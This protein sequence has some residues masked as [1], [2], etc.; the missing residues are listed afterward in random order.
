M[1]TTPSTSAR[2]GPQC[3]RAEH[4]VDAIADELTE[5]HEVA[6][7]TDTSANVMVLPTET[8]SPWEPLSLSD[9]YPAFALLYAELA[10]DEGNTDAEAALLRSRVHAHLSAGLA[11][12]AP[13]RHPSL[14]G[15][16]VSLAF[17]AHAA[18]VSFGGYAT[19]LSRLD[20]AIAAQIRQR[21]E[22]DRDRIAAGQPIGRWDGYDVISGTSG[23]G[24]YLLARYQLTGDAAIKEALRDVL[25][26]LVAV[27]VAGEVE[28]EGQPVP[29]WW[30]EHRLSLSMETGA[31]H[32]NLGLAHGVCGP[33]ALLSVAYRAGVRADRHEEA[34]EAIVTLLSRWRATTPHG[35]SWPEAVTLD[36]YRDPGPAP[37]PHRR[38]AWCYGAAGVARAL[39]L[40]GTA[41]DNQDWRAEAEAAT[42][43][44][45]AVNQVG[46]VYDFALCHGWAGFLQI[47]LRMAADTG[48]A[49]FA[50][51][52]D[53]VAERIIEAFDP[54]APF[55]YR[56]THPTMTMGPDRPGFLEGAVGI[57]LAL[58]C[59]ATGTPPRT[60]WDAALLLN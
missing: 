9:G 22:A 36:D 11:E 18:A 8:R 2:H 45:I 26:T 1:T 5:P 38:E 54:R 55:G 50:A 59:Y 25:D 27:A 20:G 19:L 29:R 47:L 56:Y 15:G 35:P 53:E 10:A 43:R 30:V 13:A 34:I 51:A 21:A 31:G 23:V 42:R 52:A 40:A 28:V 3:E 12:P 7:A 24:R 60:G 57:A 6:A 49:G 14:Y 4:I 58:R 46:V 33:L 37:E 41:L 32:L 44:A 48:D 17:A 16:A 39:Y